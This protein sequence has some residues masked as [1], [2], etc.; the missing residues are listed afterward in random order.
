M[1]EFSH[2][3][4]NATEIQDSDF[5]IVVSLNTCLHPLLGED[6]VGGDY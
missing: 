2:H 4:R 3:S 1:I 5:S 6:A